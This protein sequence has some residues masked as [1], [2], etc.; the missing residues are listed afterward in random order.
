MLFAEDAAS[1]TGM[2]P[3]NGE[4]VDKQKVAMVEF[5]FATGGPTWFNQT[6]WYVF[7]SVVLLKCCCLDLWQ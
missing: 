4:G 5:Y 1:W 6:D 7:A 3:E 2:A